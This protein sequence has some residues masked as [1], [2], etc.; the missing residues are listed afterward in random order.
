MS[1]EFS[2]ELRDWSNKPEW[3]TFPVI[4][5]DPDAWSHVPFPATLDKWADKALRLELRIQQLEDQVTFREGVIAQLKVNLK[6][7]WER[8]W[9]LWGAYD[10]S[11]QRKD[12]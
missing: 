8:F 3:A 12:E 11:T 2:K 9:V 10:K 6:E 1:N 7:L 4:V 5:D